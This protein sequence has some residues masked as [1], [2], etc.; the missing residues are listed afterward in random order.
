MNACVRTEKGGMHNDI[1]HPSAI[2]FA[3]GN[4][5]R[6]DDGLG[7]AFA[8]WLEEEGRFRGQVEYRY[9]LQIEDA[10]LI[11]RTD[12]VIFVD[13]SQEPLEG[14]FRWSVGEARG[15]AAF[16]THELSPFA[17]LH[18]AVDLYDHRPSAFLLAI[19]GAHWELKRGL[20]RQGRQHLQAA[21]DWWR[22]ELG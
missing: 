12:T 21:K 15:E 6:N 1:N 16:T 19:E 20:S 8:R 22:R 18:L 3:I 5:G 17:V 10:E 7:W 13:A 9:Q 11:S 4:D 2:L 14:G